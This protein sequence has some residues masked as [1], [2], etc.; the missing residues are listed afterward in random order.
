[1]D[2]SQP[3]RSDYP[4][5]RYAAELGDMA[6]QSLARL[7]YRRDVDLAMAQTALRLARRLPSPERIAW[8]RR[9]DAARGD[10]RPKDLPEVY[11]EQALWIH[12]HP[13]A[14]LVL[15]AVRIGQVGL[16]AIPNEVFAI[17]GLKL[18]ACS[19]MAL[20][21]NLE[22][23]NGAE[24]YIPPPEQHYLGGYTTWPAR[25]AGLE[26]EAEPKILEA[27]V[28]LLEKVSDA[29]RRPL[30]TDFYSAEQ[31]QAIERARSDDNNRENRGAAVSTTA[32]AP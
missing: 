3:Q 22:L 20:Q 25:T 27:L 26:P 4:R 13:S 1:M 21:M 5:Q 7:E 9:L 31:R 12:D 2:Y 14:D 29:K 11:A 6:I 28:C 24:G 18:K 19:P 17:T 10:R 16:T 30:E 32:T 23:A 8:A 15:Q